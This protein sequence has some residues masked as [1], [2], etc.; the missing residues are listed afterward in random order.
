MLKV[1]LG[2]A[3]VFIFNYFTQPVAFAAIAGNQ[4]C[5]EGA[6][7]S[8][9]EY[10]YDDSYSPITDATC[11]LTSRFPNGSLFLNA[12]AMTS[13]SENDGW[14]SYTFDTT[15]KSLGLYRSQ[16]TCTTDGDTLRLDKSFSIEEQ[17]D[18]Q[19]WDATASAHTQDGSFG[20]K[21]QNSVPQVSDIWNYSTRTLS[22]FGTLISDIW[23]YSSRSLT[24]FGTLVT[25][26]W[27]SATRTLTGAGLDDGESLAT[28]SNV[29]NATS[30]ATTSI[31]GSGNK[32]LTQI[33]TGIETAQT[34][35]D[36]IE[37]KVDTL[38]TNIDSVMDDTTDILSKWSTYSASDIISYVDDLESNLG[39]SS[40]ACSASTIFGGIKCVRDKWGSQTAD[41]IYLAANNAATYSAALRSELNYNGKSSTAY[42]DIQAIKTFAQTI[43]TNI[44]TSSDTSSSLTVFGKIQGTKNDI[45]TSAASIRGPSNKNLSDVSS[46]VAGVQSVVDGVSANVDTMNT[47]LEGLDEKADTILAKWG[48]YNMAQVMAAIDGLESTSLGDE[49][50]TCDDDTIFGQVN[51]IKGKWGS[52]T[53]DD[54]YNSAV[55]IETDIDSLRTELD[56]NGKSST[57]YD[58]LQSIISEIESMQSKIGSSS[59]TSSQSTLYGKL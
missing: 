12:Q 54:I 8:I 22:S 18:D 24:T 2:I 10:L 51:C 33:N 6:T 14:Y 30:S 16:I 41:G 50:D 5:V 37:T 9:G 46:E 3:F 1:A 21:L 15:G 28:K 39:E 44:G 53:A 40:D 34:S 52:R 20:S 4:R 7:C 55:N 48:S 17:I 29:D 49:N 11:T 27:S 35:L 57:A 58:D 32:D 43:D 23:S 31:K 25:D 42:E 36:S 38:D 59:D 26:V 45:A 13:A 56:Y 19:V 47:T